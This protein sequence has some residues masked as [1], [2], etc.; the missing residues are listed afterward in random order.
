MKNKKIQ[1]CDNCTEENPQ[2]FDVCWNCG[3]SLVEKNNKETKEQ[4]EQTVNKIKKEISQSKNIGETKYTFTNIGGLFLMISG[5]IVVTIVYLSSYFWD[6]TIEMTPLKVKN[7][8]D[9]ISIL[10]Y[11]SVVFFILGGFLIFID[12]ND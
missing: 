2:E 1:I 9:G 5:I 11:F 6:S 12:N 3:N 4:F 7:W 8:M 10:S